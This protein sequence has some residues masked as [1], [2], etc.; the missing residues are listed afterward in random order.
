MVTSQA[1]RFDPWLS[2]SN[3]TGGSLVTM[4][5][6]QKID[7]LASLVHCSI[8]VLPLAAHL[9]V[10]FIHPPALAYRTFVPAKGLVEQRNEL[11]DQRCTLEW[12]IY[13]LLPPHDSTA[14]IL[15]RICAAGSPA[16][17]SMR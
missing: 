12:S 7:G 3:A 16:S 1:R 14:S 15:K 17:P 4:D 6:K 11:D 13:S 2:Q 9:D 8:Q 10:G 5:S